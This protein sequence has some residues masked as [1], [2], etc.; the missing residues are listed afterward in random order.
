MGPRELALSVRTL[1]AAECREPAGRDAA[2]ACLIGRATSK[3]LAARGIGA[4][5]QEELD[6]PPPV[7]ARLNALFDHEDLRSAWA[8]GNEETI[9]ALY[10]GFNAEDLETAFRDV[11]L[12]GTKFEAGDI[13]SV[14]RLY[15]PRWIVRFLLE[16]TLGRLWVGMHPDSRL[17]DELAYVVPDAPG[18]EAARARVGLKRA[19]D[20]TVLDPACGAMHFGL[21]AFD[22]LRAM[23]REELDRAG[24]AGWPEE[25]SVESEGAIAAAILERNL[26]GL[27]I[28]P[29]SVELAALALCLKVKGIDPAL[30]FSGC[31]VACPEALPEEVRQAGSLLRPDD[32]PEIDTPFL[33]LL[34]RRY[35]VVATNP[36]Y[37]AGRKMN[38]QLKALLR[39][40]YPHGK[41]D[42]YAAF[43]ER[44]LE[45][46]RRG[47]YVGMLTM[48]SFMFTSSYAR[49]RALVGERAVLET[50][51]HLGPDL[52]EVGNPGTLQT[53]AF[54]LRPGNGSGDAAGTYV[55]LVDGGSAEAKRAA[56]EEAVAGL[57]AGEV[58]GTVFRVRP[59]DFAV[60]PGAPWV[61]WAG[62]AVRRI[63]ETFP[64]VKA[65]A[66][67]RQGLATGDNARFVRYWWEVGRDRIGFGCRDAA[68]ARASG[69][70]WFPYMKGGGFRRWWGNQ[71]YCVDWADGGR[72]IKQYVCD[73][74]P[75]LKGKWQWVVK[76]EG[77]YFRR[78]VT[79]SY[80]TSGRFSARL[81][82][83]GFIFD[84]AGSS[85]F[86][87]DEHLLLGVLNS[88]VAAH[89]LKLINPTV[90]FQ[91]GDLARLPVPPRSSPALR[92]LVEEALALARADSEEDETSYEFVAPPSWPSGLDKVA[93]RHARLAEVE[94]RID[95]EVCRLYGI[96]GQMALG[97]TERVP[98]EKRTGDRG[99]LA[100]RWISYLLGVTLGRFRCTADGATQGHLA[101]LSE[102]AQGDLAVQVLRTLEALLGDTAVRAV[103]GAALGGSDSPVR[104]LRAYLAGPFHRE[105]MRQYK[106]RPV[107]WLLQSKRKTY[108]VYLF[109]EGITAETLPRVLGDTFF[110][111]AIKHADREE[112][113]A[114]RKKLAQLR[115]W[116][117][118]IDAG[119]ARNL[120][121]VTRI[122]SA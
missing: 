25:P 51:L 39:E 3:M 23:Y 62:P 110:G 44:C 61:Y 94:R 18:G 31:N 65:V 99:E 83:G 106:K 30:P 114:F 69:K 70:R 64:P 92:S 85:L 4:G 96:D 43:I 97:G 14:T 122:V 78:G 79:Y 7:R 35:D 118:D 42:L 105:H 46:A 19:R 73:R 81:S 88:S 13:P 90:N 55:R 17:R 59:R 2:L 89:L 112:L 10:E 22:L 29:R 100:R 119:I 48:H 28:D 67:P 24:E 104:R 84:V 77:Y 82:P 108:G 52:F 117:H 21:V 33:R 113:A 49:L 98:V 27:D 37:M 68:Q 72:E 60:I 66:P 87:V 75:Y 76:N 50:L 26:Y 11:R 38:R 41:R 93:D 107:Y 45:F 71:I 109:H 91:V 120:S 116:T 15:T 40:R 101:P 57:R 63:F 20:I 121:R 47:G 34:G 6:L 5:G 58:G 111:P 12:G 1:L 54:I 80:L 95:E 103:L 56:F 36:P 9:G 8:P 32:V 86:P 102:G 115:S 74:Y 53:A 16:N